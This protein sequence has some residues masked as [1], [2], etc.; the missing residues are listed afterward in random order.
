M[1]FD[2]PLATCASSRERTTSVRLVSS[3]TVSTCETVCLWAGPL[4]QKFEKDLCTRVLFLFIAPAAMSI[5][6]LIGLSEDDTF[7]TSA[8]VGFGPDFWI[9]V[10]TT[11]HWKGDTFPLGLGI[12]LFSLLW[13]LL[14]SSLRRL[15]R[16][17]RLCAPSMRH[18]KL[19]HSLV[20]CWRT[21]LPLAILLLSSIVPLVSSIRSALR[22]LWRVSSVAATSGSSSII[23]LRA[24]SRSPPRLQRPLVR[25]RPRRDV[26]S[27]VTG[28][29][30]GSLSARCVALSVSPLSG[31][32]FPLCP[33][34]N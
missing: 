8:T 34:N 7:R 11:L 28:A 19:A 31:D 5:S 32:V 9:P 18:G 23:S 24:R 26:S 20:L 14:Q 30:P 2:V 17:H 27:V 33:F 21:L 6:P 1:T 22:S 12:R 25:L 4:L 10:F 13:A 29:S 16:V 3:P 15:P